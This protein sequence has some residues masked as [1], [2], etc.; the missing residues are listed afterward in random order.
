MKPLLHTKCL[1]QAAEILGLSLVQIDRAGVVNK[2]LVNNAWYYFISS[3]VP[4][5]SDTDARLCADKAYTYDI[6]SSYISMPRTQVFLDPYHPKYGYFSPYKSWDEIQ[7]SIVQ[8]FSFPLI[9]KRNSGSEGDHVYRCLSQNDAEHAL[10][11]IF[12]QKHPEYDHVLLAQEYIAAHK[13]Y[14][15]ICLDREVALAYEK[16]T[17]AAE[18]TGNLSPLHWPGSKAIK[19]TDSSKLQAFQ[20]FLAPIFAQ[21]PVRYVGADV[22]EDQAG[23]LWLIELNARPGY[24]HFIA[25]NGEADIVELYAQI[26]RKAADDL[27]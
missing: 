22:I 10:S 24:E 20:S 12:N 13:E 11:Q 17:Q 7:K 9:I 6:L 21:W 1:Q 2:V 27:G 8:N 15:V 3:A 5:N 26:L 19:V 4:I 18:F 25:D 16:N 14:R 23:K